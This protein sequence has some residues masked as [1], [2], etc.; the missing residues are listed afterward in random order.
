M[1]KMPTAGQPGKAVEQLY[2]GT[3]EFN[4]GYMQC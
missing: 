1:A 3:V 4:L 2:S